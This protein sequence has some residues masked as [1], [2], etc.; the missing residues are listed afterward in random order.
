[1]DEGGGRW[2]EEG[3]RARGGERRE[4]EEGGRKLAQPEKEEGEE[5][6][7]DDWYVSHHLFLFDF[8][9]NSEDRLISWF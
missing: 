3:T 8:L 7:A 1:M 9:L 6:F 4:L 2:L 5:T